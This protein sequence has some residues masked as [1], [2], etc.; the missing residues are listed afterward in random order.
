MLAAVSK[1]V[2]RRLRNIKQPSVFPTT[3]GTDCR[4]E[5]VQNSRH[6]NP[7]SNRVMISPPSPVKTSS[8]V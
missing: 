1:R 8:P 4:A 7:Q 2:A 5:A 6:R 3:T